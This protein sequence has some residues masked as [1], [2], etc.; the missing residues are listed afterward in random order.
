MISTDTCIGCQACVDCCPAQAISFTYD[1]WGDGK[2]HVNLQ[3]CV[4]YSL[5]DSICPARKMDLNPEQKNVFAV[6]SK[7]NSKKGS[8]GGF[9]FEVASKFLRSGGVV[10]GAAFDENLKLC[11]VCVKK[12]DDLI[13]LCKSKYVHSDM[14]GIYKQ[15]GSNLKQGI[16]VMFVGTPCQTSAVKNLYKKK[17]RERVLLVD[18]LCHGT[19]TQKVFD[20]CKTYEEQHKNGRISDFCFRSKS[21]K[22]EHSF[23]YT[24]NTMGR[25]KTVSGYSFEYPYYNGYLSYTI[26][27]DACYRCE[28]TK[29]MRVGDI[30]LGDFWGIQNFDSHLK[31]YKGVS[32]ISVNTEL[33]DKWFARV[34][35]NC[36]QKSF[37]IECA[38]S[39]NQS[40][41]C[42]VPA[43]KKKKK[44]LVKLLIENGSDALVEELKCHNIP[45]SIIYAMTPQWVIRVYDRVRGRK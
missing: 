19:G 6:V 45:K 10:Y 33:G 40:F 26:F 11:H 4:N 9:F 23:T 24:L 39:K 38:T 35:N 37:P 14:E 22:A 20:I 2:A 3:K 27:Q 12:V 7:I 30:T 31:D 43:P 42:C 34:I 29:T 44:Q 41:T 28:Y 25:K 18:F 32:M 16:P 5:C 8:S 21:R 17:Y 13:P 36:E 15:I 1:F